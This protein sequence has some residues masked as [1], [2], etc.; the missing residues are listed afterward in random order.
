[1][2]LKNKDFHRLAV[3]LWEVLSPKERS[4]F[5]DGKF[6]RLEDG[7]ELF[8][9]II[10]HLGVPRRYAPN[11]ECP[12]EFLEPLTILQDPNILIPVSSPAI[13]I[14]INTKAFKF[15]L[16]RGAVGGYADAWVDDRRRTGIFTLSRDA[17][18]FLEIFERKIFSD[19]VCKYYFCGDKIMAQIERVIKNCRR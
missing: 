15:L 16:A 8:N 4:R 12:G 1:M 14:G 13:T 17:L 19:Y 7:L 9:I 5:F 6:E 2:K 10:S 3:G 11:G 18:E